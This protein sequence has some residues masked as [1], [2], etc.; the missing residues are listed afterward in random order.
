[1]Q[2]F[3]V[4]KSTA[5]RDVLTMQSMGVPLYTDL[6]KYGGY[7]VMDTYALPPVLFT[8]NETY[9]LFFA[10]QCLKSFQST[11][12]EIEFRSM[13]AKFYESLSRDNKVAIS[14]LEKRV[15]L[16]QPEHRNISTSLR[17]LLEASIR[18]SPLLITYAK[19][20]K[21]I[22]R[23]IQPIGILSRE[24]NWYCSAYDFSTKG[25]RVFRCD[26]IRKV[27][28]SGVAP[29]DLGS[30]TVQNEYDLRRRSEE[31]VD[32]RVRLT[33]EGVDIYHKNNYPSFATENT[34]Y[35][36]YLVGWYEPNELEFVVNY[37]LVFG[38]T[39]SIIEPLALRM[40]MR[41][42]LEEMIGL[43]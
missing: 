43:C 37:L 6:G 19:H 2:S 17:V 10:M 11:P 30:Y 1:M 14:A 13:A 22:R 15:L 36:M 38:K 41:R 25:Y 39:A 20:D 21:V 9:A 12:F 35:G 40:A 5:L 31:A 16:H 26:R 29:V 42:R 7:R 18:Q 34:P 4:S 28:E 24:G 32:L 23:D 3:G 33:R 8:K 27:G